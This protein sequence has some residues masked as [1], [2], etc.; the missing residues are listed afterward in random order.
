MLDLRDESCRSRGRT[1]VPISLEIRRLG[2]G[3]CL[4]TRPTL[5]NLLQLEKF[6][7]VLGRP[8]LIGATLLVCFP[9]EG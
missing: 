1:L 3:R 2:S 7:V 6:G 9:V 4:A 8:W 5:Q